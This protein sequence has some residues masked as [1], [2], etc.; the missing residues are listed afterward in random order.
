M[1]ILNRKNLIMP[2]HWLG[3]IVIGAVAGVF[4]GMFGIGGGVVI[5]PALVIFLGFTE[6]QAISTS[7]GA[8][9]LPVGFFAI[10]AYRRKG[11]LHLRAA[12]WLSFGLVL[13]TAIGSA[14][15]LQLDAIDPD[16]L[17]RVYGVFLLYIGWR[18]IAPRQLYAQWRGQEVNIIDDTTTNPDITWWQPFLVGLVAGIASGMFGIGG[19]A[20][21]V[22]ALTTYFKFDQKLAVG[23]SLTALLL[24]VGLPGAIVYWNSGT[25]NIL[26]AAL[27]AVGLDI[28]S[29]FGAKIA[30]G[31]SSTTV[32]RLYG[33]FLYFIA[34][35]FI[36]G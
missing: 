8:L 24:P 31:L 29:R 4:S 2:T 23:T 25:L 1:T 36:F 12:G 14:G 19:G 7:L 34:I 26:V 5:V 33:G 10:L 22:P 32:K 20:I 17:K 18:F 27:V 13:T 35:R 11:Y 6:I 15:A 30:L 16:L 28:G 21:I 3:L 9:L